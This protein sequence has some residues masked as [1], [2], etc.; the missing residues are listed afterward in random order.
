MNISPKWFLTATVASFSAS[1]GQPVF[2]FVLSRGPPL[3]VHPQCLPL[4]TTLDSQVISEID[5]PTYFFQLDVVGGWSFLPF[6]PFF[7]HFTWRMLKPS[8]LIRLLFLFSPEV[9]RDRPATPFSIVR[10]SINFSTGGV[11]E[12]DHCRPPFQFI[13]YQPH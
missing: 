8:D 11:Q 2:L 13:S 6:D 10:V 7:F 1:V 12:R 3:C 4:P 9:R 5:F